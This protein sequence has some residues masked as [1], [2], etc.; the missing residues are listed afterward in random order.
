[1]KNARIKNIDIKK[2][3][4]LTGPTETDEGVKT[5][6]E[7]NS[8]LITQL[9]GLNVSKITAERLV[10]NITQILLKNGLRQLT[11]PMPTIRQ[12]I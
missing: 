4:Y 11:L 12:P 8:V 1:M 7:D 2:I 3:P 10:K 5:I 9:V 6:S